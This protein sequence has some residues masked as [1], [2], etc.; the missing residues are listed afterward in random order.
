MLKTLAMLVCVV[1]WP[2]LHTKPV[3]TPA[4]SGATHEAPG[5]PTT[6]ECLFPCGAGCVS[7]VTTIVILGADGHLHAVQAAICGCGSV[8]ATACCQ[9]ALYPPSVKGHGVATGACSF[10]C[11]G[12]STAS[13]CT[14]FGVQA[15]PDRE[16]PHGFVRYLARC[17]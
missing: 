17:Q 14:A 7:L 16:H 11:S 1:V 15:P 3:P 12:M 9:I 6:L 10:D 2:P 13:A 8:P 5:S 4:C